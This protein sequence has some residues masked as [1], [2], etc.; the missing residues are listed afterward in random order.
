MAE[1]HLWKFPRE[2]R[3]QV[4]ADV[5]GGKKS[6]VVDAEDWT[7]ERHIPHRFLEFRP[8]AYAGLLLASKTIS[9]EFQEILYKN[10]V[11][12]AYLCKNP[13]RLVPPPR[14]EEFARI[15]KIE[16]ILDVS[17]QHS[18]GNPVTDTATHDIREVE[19]YYR[20]WFLAFG[21]SGAHRDFCRIR[22]TSIVMRSF[23]CTPVY[24]QLLQTCTTFTGFRTVIVELEER[25]NIGV[26]RTHVQ[27][28]N[29][30]LQEPLFA[31]VCCEATKATIALKL[32]PFLGQ[33]I[34]YDR[35]DVR[36]LEFRPRTDEPIQPG[37]EPYVQQQDDADE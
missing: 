19:G 33:C 30:P 1:N 11:F 3:D 29:E 35:G 23:H 26:Q 24:R 25:P 12:R 15:Q 6:M 21:G 10:S 34:Y 32:R 31:G 8:P 14:P 37:C 4:Y 16:I 5:L 22:I 17:I 7:L 2:L 27:A 9:A 20:E 36:C 18:R 13:Y 28:G